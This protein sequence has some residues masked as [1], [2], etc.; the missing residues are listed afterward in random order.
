MA[1]S[2]S[3]LCVLSAGTCC[4]TDAKARILKM[5]RDSYKYPSSIER[6]LHHIPTRPR[7][8]ACIGS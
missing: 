1:L 6:Q 4:V 3:E 7:H 5:T 2:M 8:N